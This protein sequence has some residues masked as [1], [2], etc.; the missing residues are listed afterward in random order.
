MPAKELQDRKKILVNQLN[1]LIAT[2]KNYGAGAGGMDGEHLDPS[3]IELGVDG[4]C[5]TGW[6]GFRVGWDP[7][8]HNLII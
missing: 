4:E 2:K 5:R 3:G 8:K 7:K 6:L 1:T